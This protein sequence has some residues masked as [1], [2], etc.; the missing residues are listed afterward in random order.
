MG[1]NWILDTGYW[2]F[3]LCPSL[4]AK[5]HY[6]KLRLSI[7]KGGIRGIEKQF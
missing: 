4:L 2:R 6:L 7:S 5:C 1:F 3:C